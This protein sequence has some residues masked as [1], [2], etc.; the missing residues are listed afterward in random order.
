[1]NSEDAGET[2]LHCKRSVNN[3]GLLSELF[4]WK[5]FTRLLK[6]LHPFWG[7]TS[8]L[9]VNKSYNLI[10]FANKFNNR[11]NEKCNFSFTHFYT[12]QGSFLSLLRAAA[13]CCWNQHDHLS[14]IMS[15][16]GSRCR[17]P[18]C[19]GM[20]RMWLADYKCY[21]PTLRVC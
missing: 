13:N 7:N 3:F 18:R 4:W 20:H 5:E 15:L 17:L 11:E 12:C 9:L 2:Y 10:Y 6:I 21:P 19:V 16:R 14:E 1:M 8:C